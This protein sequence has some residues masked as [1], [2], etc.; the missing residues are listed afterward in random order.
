[1]ASA[2]LTQPRPDSDFDAVIGVDTHRDF[3]VAVAVSPNGARLDEYRISTNP[4]GYQALLGW[5]ELFGNKPVF[6]MEGTNSF[7]AGLCRELMAAGFVVVEAN[8]PDR[9]TRRRLGKDDGIDAEMAARAFLAGTAMA[10][11]KSGEDQV[12]MIR[13]LKVAKDSAIDARTKAINQMRAL[14]VTATPAL[15]ERLNGLSRGELISTCAAFRAGAL[16]GPLA[17]AKQALRTLARRV[18]VLDAELDELLK[19][20]DVLTQEACPGMR[21]TYGIGVD[22]AAILLTA[23]GDNPESD[24][25][26]RL[27][28]QRSAEPA[29]C[30]QAQGIPDVIDSTAV[31]TGRP[32][33]LYIALQSVG[34]ATTRPQKPTQNAVAAKVSVTRKSCA[35]SSGSSPGRFS[36]YSWDEIQ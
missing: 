19:D 31:A 4:R 5:S 32:L 28:S 1:M 9:S 17:A 15:R 7:G 10:V 35:A 26:R 30:R 20:L 18:Q 3:H 6:A 27:H 33:R 8:R 34:C 14:L 2:T 24:C 23:A 25:A 13:M 21:Q 29:L 12:E 16:V 11:P 36:T 22:G